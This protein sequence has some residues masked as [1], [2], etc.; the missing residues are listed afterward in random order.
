M[1]NYETA[2]A[3]NRGWET[4]AEQ[5][6]LRHKKIAIAGLGGVGGQYLHTLA[7]MG[8][9]GFSIADFDRFDWPNFNRQAGAFVSTVGRP[10]LDVMREA[11]LDINPEVQLSTFP[12]GVDRDNLD[13]FL[14]G[15]DLYIDSLDFFALDIRRAVFKACY[16]RGIPAVTAAPLGMGTAFL[17]FLPGKMS[18]DEYFGLEGQEPAEQA[19]RFLVGLA[20]RA[21]HVGY[22]AD[23]SR[24]NLEAKEGPS[25][26]MAIQLCAGYA[27]VQA[28]KLLL[29]RGEVA[30]A[31]WGL[32]FDAYTGRLKRTWTPGGYRNP[33]QA[34]K[35]AVARRMLRRSTPAA[36]AQAS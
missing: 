9:G 20:P 29:G 18:F 13:E 1:F 28:I 16:E 27:C 24:V 31:P 21:L 5:Q 32:Q 8:I 12:K 26:A 33:I 19:V 35:L 11:A 7:R 22:L 17:A 15:V 25:T 36:R 34:L 14:A 30:P 6:V 4:P 2:F 10:K 3:R 23:R